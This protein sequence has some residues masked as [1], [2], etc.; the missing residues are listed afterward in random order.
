MASEAVARL[1]GRVEDSYAVFTRWEARDEGVSDAWID[2]RLA[3]GYLARLQPNVLRVV[4][5][6]ITW[7]TKAMAGVKAVT[8]PDTNP[9]NRAAAIG[10]ASAARLLGLGR[11]AKEEPLEIVATGTTL[12]LLW[13]VT[14]HRTRRLPPVDVREVDGIPCT[15]GTRTGIDLA[16]GTDRIE[17][18]TILDELI[19]ARLSTR[20]WMHRRAVDLAPGR[21]NTLYLARMTA[22]GA[23]AEF[24]SWLE[25]HGAGVFRRGRLPAPRWNVPIQVNGKRFVADALFDPFQIITELDGPKFHDPP[26]KAAKDKARDRKLQIANYVVLRFPYWEV[27]KT[28]DGVVAEIFDALRA[29]GFVG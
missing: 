6:P 7:R 16:T 18:L 2:S 28:P 17:A 29:R 5:A 20:W 3:A 8:D 4:G 1:L 15:T 27:V 21:R 11:C 23:R 9:R 12:P 22:E 25:S 10:F 13:D 26:D 19:G 24:R 14:V